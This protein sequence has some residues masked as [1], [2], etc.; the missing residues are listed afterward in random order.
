MAARAKI[1]IVDDR[2]EDRYLLEILLKGSGYQVVSAF[3]GL[4]ALEK[5]RENG[6]D[7]I[8]SDVLMPKMD[9]FQ[10]C[11]ECKADET[12]KNIPFIFY[13]ATYTD[14][15]DQE[16]ALDLGAEKYI[17]KPLEPD[18]LLK[19]IDQ[20]IEDHKE[21]KFVTPKEP[22]VEEEVFLKQYSERLINRLEQK[23]LQLEKEVTKRRKT[24]EELKES[25]GK[26]RDLVELLPQALFEIDL[27]GNITFANR[28]AFDYFGYTQ[29]DVDLGLN[30]LR[31]LVPEDHDRV[32]NNIKRVIN[33]EK[34]GGIEYTTLT[35]DGRSTPVIIYADAICHEDKLVGLRGIAVDITERKQAEE[36]IR[37]S[38][39]ELNAVIDGSPIPQFVIDKDHYVTHW[40][41]AL[42]KYS[43][44]KAEDV[45]GTNKHCR[46]FYTEERP[47]LADL[48]VIEAIEKIPEW[49]RGKFNESKFVEE[50]YEAIDFFPKMGN[51]GKW[52][53][54]T[55]ATINDDEGNIIGAVETLE[56]I[57]ERKIAEDQ[58]K[59]SLEEKELLIQEIHH[60]VKNNMQV[61]SSLI[62]LQSAHVLDERDRDLFYASRDRVKTM[63]K[64]HEKL[65]LS[66]N[67]AEIN[68]SEYLQSLVSE[69]FIS[70]NVHPRVKWKMDLED[71]YLGVDSAVPCGLIMNELVTNSIKHAFPDDME[72]EITIKIRSH[73]ETVVMFVI[74]N[75]VGVPEDLDFKN[76]KT[77]GLQLVNSLVQQ[78]DG[79]IELDRDHGTQF[80]FSLKNPHI[81]KGYKP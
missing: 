72:G 30:I 8:I 64:V 32:K 13:S 35:K 65:Y 60:R 38:E 1:L 68:F 21:K 14:I 66:K 76:T 19:I 22:A 42:E 37:R 9:G 5:L 23:V 58:I 28:F 29:D 33:G 15:K 61:I 45:I 7:L 51:K 18:M 49:Y 63:A 11:R 50:V 74:D 46:A 54:F 24:E 81:K 16:F 67:M 47:C 10:L 39:M 43:G 17:I 4:E 2:E 31:I 77:L 69:L 27:M 40:N 75:G 73:D 62:T 78:L 71:V 36:A 70:Y 34:L 12:L 53:Y 59:S 26:Y 48:L 44:V 55:A 20:V 56:D 57:T 80:K 41:K 52:L 6:F 3:N 25:Q 79:T